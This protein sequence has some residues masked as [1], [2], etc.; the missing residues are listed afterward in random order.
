MELK[1]RLELLRNN[2]DLN[3]FVRLLDELDIKRILFELEFC[4]YKKV[5]FNS[6][7]S[8]NQCI[9]LQGRRECLQDLLNFFDD[10]LQSLISTKDGVSDLMA[11]YGDIEDGN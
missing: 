10:K 7:D 6:T 2:K 8:L 9:Y 1:D 4:A 5:V 3:T 11:K